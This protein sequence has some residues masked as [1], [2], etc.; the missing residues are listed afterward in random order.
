MAT[1]FNY[2][3]NETLNSVRRQGLIVF[4]AVTTT[5]ISLVLF[6]FAL[7]ISRE[8]NLVY[9]ATTEKVEV[10]VF[11]QDT[12]SDAD[13]AR[14]DHMLV[15]MP[16]VESVR[17]ESKQ[18]AYQRF[19]EIFSNQRAITENVGS[20]ALPASFRV[21]LRDP[22]KYRVVAARLQGQPG[23]SNIVDQRH[24]L[25][26]LFS[27]LN[28]LKT[29]AFIAGAVVLISAA[30]LIGNTVRMAVFSR[31]REIGIMRLVGATNWFIR[32]PFM[33]EGVAEALLG[34]TAAVIALF[35]LKRALFDSLQNKV[36]FF[37]LLHNGDLLYVIPVLLGIGVIVAGAASMVAMRRFLEV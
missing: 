26:R 8:V 25:D 36:A 18:Q 14:L 33:I 20:D 28:V 17:Y 37:P 11:L 4:A 13:R 9:D 2:Y 3:F 27:I 34:A 30:A 12:I 19:K 10:A 32:I 21:K 23:I 31:R 15:D 6:G 5:F 16:E 35:L 7:L 22:E 1:R 24:V 29:G